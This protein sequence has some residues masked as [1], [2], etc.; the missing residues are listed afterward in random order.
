MTAAHVYMADKDGK[1]MYQYA[2]IGWAQTDALTSNTDSWI[3][4]VFPYLDKNMKVLNCASNRWRSDGSPQFFPTEEEKC[5]YVA[6]GILTHFGGSNIHPSL[7]TAISDDFATSNEAIL[8][9]HYY[10]TAPSLR[11]GK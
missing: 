11:E 3:S 1:V 6:N 7:V 2:G 4:R 10:G 5:S 8:R 9:P